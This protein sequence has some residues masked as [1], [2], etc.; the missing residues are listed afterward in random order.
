MAKIMLDTDE[1]YPYPVLNESSGI[2][3]EVPQ[4]TL[5]RWQRVMGEF[6]EVLSEI[7]D[8]EEAARKAGKEYVL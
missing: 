2:E 3:I 7:W 5:D 6:H 4:E 1:L 8:A